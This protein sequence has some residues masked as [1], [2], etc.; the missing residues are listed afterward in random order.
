[1]S[2]YDI[3]ERF[4]FFVSA[5]AGVGMLRVCDLCAD[6]LEGHTEGRVFSQDVDDTCDSCGIDGRGLHPDDDDLE[7]AA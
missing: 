6:D 5:E 4:S 7:V 1:M 2:A 3:T